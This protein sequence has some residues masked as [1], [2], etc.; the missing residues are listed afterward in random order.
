VT[1]FGPDSGSA[2]EQRRWAEPAVGTPP[3]HPPVDESAA[4]D[5]RDPQDPDDTGGTEPTEVLPRPRPPISE[6]PTTALPRRTPPQPPLGYPPNY[7]PYQADPGYRGQPPVRPQRPPRPSGAPPPSG[8]PPRTSPA[9]GQPP[10]YPRYGP[11]GYPPGTLPPG[12]PDAYRP[13]YQGRPPDQRTYY[14][15]PVDPAFPDPDIDQPRFD[16]GSEH[17]PA[18]PGVPPRAGPPRGA[19][20]PPYREPFAG[21]AEA[22]SGAG[23]IGAGAAGAAAG[24]ARPGGRMPRKITVTRVAAMRSREL[25]LR[26]VEMFHRATTA[27]GADRSGLAHL[28]Y[29]QMANY[30]CDAAL[31]VALANTL[32]LVNP[33][34]GP[35]RVLLYLL[36][37]VAPFAFVAPVIGPFLDRLQTGRRLALAVSMGGRGLLAIP[38]IFTFSG[39]NA[40]WVLYPCALGSLVF[41]KSFGVLKA[42]LTPRVLPHE[43]TLV[44]TNSRLTVFGLIA[45]GAAGAIAAGLTWMFGSPGALVFT[46]LLGFGGAYLCFQIPAW[47]ESTE[48]EVPVHLTAKPTRNAPA[49][50]TT[51][52]RVTLWANSSIRIETGFLAMFIAFVVMKEYS[53]ETGFYKLML[54]G[55]V[56]GAAGVGGFIGN[57][58]GAK[59]PLRSPELISTLALVATLVSTLL[60]A[61]M[62]GLAMAAIVGFIGST[63]SSLAKVCLDS[64]IQRDLPEVSRA[65]AFGRSE[66]SLQLGWVFGG[67]VGLLIG[68]L[69]NLSHNPVYTI[70]FS[71]ATVLLALGL[72][73]TWLARTGRSLIPQFRMPRRRGRGGAEPVREPDGTYTTRISFGDA[74]DSA[75]TATD[76]PWPA[77]PSSAPQ[78]TGRPDSTAKM[79]A[80]RPGRRRL[81]NGKRSGDQ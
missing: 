28:T 48:G 54:L 43:I 58:L 1:A 76:Q 16:G 39:A 61:L 77:G 19:H 44:A 27:D 30:A 18:G 26:G 49:S 42:S 80:A 22:G 8:Y 70:G 53:A 47:V 21:A 9:Q 62:P 20:L 14:G 17:Y 73:Q 59:L 24:S 34:E 29:A 63:A 51:A 25:T 23:A 57:A 6:Q 33:E 71:A 32:F 5:P 35:G 66:T 78:P 60:A 74:P 55:L 31:A 40:S 45:G 12:Q 36:I 11:P 10:T 3:K 65:S 13:D 72:L 67:V 46:A 4:S 52:V 56:G 41:S 50:L 68:G 81:R 7:Q 2:D 79:P 15:N 37:T 75:T 38:M 69:L 64:V